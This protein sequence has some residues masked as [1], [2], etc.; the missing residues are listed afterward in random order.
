MLRF[1][2]YESV[3][4]VLGV[5]QVAGRELAKYLEVKPSDLEAI[6]SAL[7]AVAS[8]ITAEEREVIDRAPYSLGVALER[9]PVQTAAPDLPP[10]PLGTPPFQPPPAT[11][12]HIHQMPAVRDQGNRGTCVAFA[13]LAAYEHFLRLN[14]TEVELSEQFLYWNCK[15][16]DGYAGQGTWLQVAY[17][18][19]RQDGCCLA[20]RWPYAPDAVLA[21]PAPTFHASGA[22]L[23]QA[24]P[25][26]VAFEAALRERDQLFAAYQQ[27]QKEPPG[28]DAQRRVST[29][30]EQLKVLLEPLPEVVPPRPSPVAWLLPYLA[31][32]P[33]RAAPERAA[34]LRQLVEKAGITLQF[35]A[36]PDVVVKRGPGP[37]HIEFGLAF[38]ERLWISAYA[39]TALA[40]ACRRQDPARVPGIED[41]SSETKGV[42]AAVYR[43]E[44]T[45]T[46]LPWPAEVPPPDPAEEPG[47]AGFTAAELFLTIGAWMFLREVGCTTES[48]VSRPETGRLLETGEKAGPFIREELAADDWAADWLLT[49]WR[50]YGI[51][52]DAVFLKRSISGAV[53]VALLEARQT[54]LEARQTID[55]LKGVR[56]AE[57]L[58]ELVA[59]L[60]ESGHPAEALEAALAMAHDGL[61]TVVLAGLA[62]HLP[63]PLLRRALED[64]LAIVDDGLRA[65][66]LAGLAPHLPEPLLRRALEAARAISGRRSAPALAGL[67]LR[68]A[69]LGHPAEALE[70]AQAVADDDRRA[71]A[72]EALAPQ[73]AKLGHPAEALEAALAIADDGLRAKALAGLA[74]HLPEP[75]LRRALEATL[76][77]RFDWRRAEALVA[78]APH[79]PEPLLRRALEDVLAIADGGRRAKVL[80]ELA[81]HLPEPLLRRAL[82]DV[83]AIA[84]GGRRAEALAG[85]A[86]LL[87]EPLLRRALEA[88]EAIRDAPGR[89]LALARLGKRVPSSKW[90]EALQ[91][92]LESVGAATP[93]HRLLHYL[94]RG[95]P[96]SADR[97]G[98]SEGLVWS[99]AWLLVQLSDQVGREIGY[100]SSI[101]N[102]AFEILHAVKSQRARR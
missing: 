89:A 33:F 69:E 58:L 100:F 91:E 50:G 85:L 90:K 13:A 46:P 63:E 79:L 37:G 28:P 75:L 41:I 54:I 68:L 70:A 82:E 45:G 60:A 72:L 52:G 101:N 35:A 86:P 57:T 30:E 77:I 62:P 34:E 102:N 10:A 14:G 73:L 5:L 19:L 24:A 7:Q 20:D 92:A 56:F 51:A 84:D 87:P 36:D 3:E 40:N 26:L 74:P 47:P 71:G 88:A 9:I 59:R 8:P 64:V 17:E 6:N 61:Q 98:G 66:A 80:A 32:A 48:L 81:P 76:A 95:V 1:L 4:E 31:A 38:A 96:L 25:R 27:L 83:L 12:S 43:A 93:G 94:N 49:R 97:R 67:A 16:H 65:E 44:M 55:A 23:T 21:G 39:H 78:L 22:I 15:A 18:M 11:V 99:M 29:L 42:L 53:G 2:G